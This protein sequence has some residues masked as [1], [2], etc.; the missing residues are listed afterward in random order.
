MEP[1]LLKPSP[2]PLAE[3]WRQIRTRYVPLVVFM[4]VLMMVISL[5]HQEVSVI[6][7]R[8]EVLGSKAEVSSPSSG[9]IVQMTVSKFQAV[10]E[11]EEIGRI[12]TT[13]PEIV[14]ASLA[15][16]QAEISLLRAG[17]GPM[18]NAERNR[19]SYLRMKFDEVEQRVDLAT[20]KANLI[21][22]EKELQRIEILVE[23]G[24]SSLDELDRAEAI[25]EG[26]TAEVL[27]RTEMVKYL[28]ETLNSLAVI[29]EKDAPDSDLQLTAALELQRKKLALAEKRLQPV[30]L[31]APISG[32]ISRIDRKSGE[33]IR[34]GDTVA[35]IRSSK[36]KSIIAYI[37]DYQGVD[38]REGDSVILRRHIN[39]RMSAISTIKKV[40]PQIQTLPTR[41]QSTSNQTEYGLPVL[42]RYPEELNA[43]PG[44]QVEVRILPDPST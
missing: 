11:G 14:T 17:I 15:V 39:S 12:L 3:R 22:A 19:L 44:E 33:N 21:R 28:N 29:F 1:Q 2:I 20:S 24:A 4:S 13:P 40:G 35:V 38:P 18:V 36:P 5:W 23:Q 10:M 8:G 32:I 34:A 27:E 43:R 25:N 37:K 31:T 16:I 9:S 6:H 7:F 42:I 41:L 30:I 26:L